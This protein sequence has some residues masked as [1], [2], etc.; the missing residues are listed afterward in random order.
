MNTSEKPYYLAYEARYR[1]VYGAG[2]DHWGHTPDDAELTEMLTAWVDKHGLRGKRILEF[3]CGEGAAGVILSRLGCIY[4]GVDISP[5]AVCAAQNAL[6]DIPTAE[7]SVLD[8]VHTHLPAQYD[9]ALDSM[10]FHMLITDDDRA[11]YLENAFAALKPGAPM[12]F[13]KESYRNAQSTV[14]V[15]REPVHS[16]EEW[17]ALTGGDYHTPMERTVGTPSGEVR[18]FVPLVPARANDECGYR[19]EFTAAGFS[20]E[21]FREMNV[22]AAIAY[23]ASIEV[24]KPKSE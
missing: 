15:I 17:I 24:R 18:V 23:A 19:A 20:V 9:A 10:G 13:Y 1:A 16:I 11:S 5:T 14:P 6:R 12:L 22:S 7:V 3:A 4:H 2:A 21:E 8:M